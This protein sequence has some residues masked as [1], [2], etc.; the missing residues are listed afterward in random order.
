MA[1]AKIKAPRTLADIENHPWVESTHTEWDGCFWTSD[2]RE[3]KGRWVYLRTGYICEPMEC[4]TI[5]ESSIRM[6]CDML[7]QSRAMTEEEM[8][9]PNHRYSDEV[10]AE[11]LANH[12]RYGT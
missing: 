9:G 5:H 3:L 6:C 1:Q 12:E 7:R 8:R 11:A 2:G 10:V 4:G